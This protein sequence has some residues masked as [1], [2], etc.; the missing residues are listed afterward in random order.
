MLWQ[1]E[2]D[3]QLSLPVLNSNSQP[4]KD[5][6]KRVPIPFFNSKVIWTSRDEIITI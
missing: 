5:P 1:P 4:S 3:H 6:T 2:E